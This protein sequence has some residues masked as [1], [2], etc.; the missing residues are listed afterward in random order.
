MCYQS[1]RLKVMVRDVMFPRAVYNA[2][3][4]IACLNGST[5]LRVGLEQ[6][7]WTWK[8]RSNG[9]RAAIDLFIFP[10]TYR[11]CGSDRFVS[12]VCPLCFCGC[13][14]SP[15]VFEASKTRKKGNARKRSQK[16]RY[17]S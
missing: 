4:N 15:A 11:S 6:D 5:V 1:D 10:V 9:Q 13:C 3:L 2:L 7:Y 8:H 16:R 12:V 17:K 14:F